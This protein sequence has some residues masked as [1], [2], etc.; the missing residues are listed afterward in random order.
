MDRIEYENVYFISIHPPLAG[1]DSTIFLT[2]S[3][4][5]LFQSTRPSR[6]GTPRVDAES[7][8]LYYFNPPAPRGTGHQRRLKLPV[9]LPIFQSTRPSRDGTRS[10][11]L[12]AGPINHFNPPAPRGTGRIIRWKFFVKQQFQSTRPSR[13]GT[14]PRIREIVTTIFQSTRPSRDGTLI[15]NFS[16]AFREFQS[17]R[18]SRDGTI[19]HDVAELRHV[20]FNPPAPRGTGQKGANMTYYAQNFNP[21]APRGTGP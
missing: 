19:Q 3:A 16:E 17:T 18:P 6:D 20:Y 13:D 1:R 9:F 2:V 7:A 8:H 10:F 5:D 15:E 11:F 4:M 21:P 12:D 14:L